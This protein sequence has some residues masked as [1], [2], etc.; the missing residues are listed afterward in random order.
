MDAPS[1]PQDARCSSLPFPLKNV[2]RIFTLDPAEMPTKVN[3]P[4]GMVY[5]FNK[6]S[7]QHPQAEAASIKIGNLASVALRTT[8]YTARHVDKGFSTLAIVLSGDVNIYTEESNAC[9]FSP[10]DIHLNPRN[11]GTIEGGHFSGFLCQIDHRKLKIAITGLKGDE[12]PIDL[13]QSHLFRTSRKKIRVYSNRRL[14]GFYHYIDQL[15]G[16]SD[17]F[18]AGLGLDEQLYRLL[19]LSLIESVGAIERVEKRWKFATDNWTTPMDELVDFIRSNIQMNITLADLEKQSCYSARHLQNLFRQKFNCTP[20]QFVRRQKLST[21]ME[22]LETA[23]DDETVTNIARDCG[24]RY[25]SNFSTD[26]QREYGVS[27]S[28]VLR[29]SRGRGNHINC[30]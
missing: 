27:P 16:E 23:N 15:L 9:Q 17:Y 1:K 18:A 26:F 14:F 25:T 5:L 30:G 22:K 21:A 13:E 4:C 28:V 2:E 12:I 11:G 6:R 7:I 29:A 10:G 19:A 8:P 20:M 24:Y 3:G